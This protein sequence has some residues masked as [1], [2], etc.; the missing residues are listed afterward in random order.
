MR[1]SITLAAA[2]SI[3]IALPNGTPFP[4]RDIV[5]FLAFGV[6]VVSLVLQGTTL[7]ALIRLLGIRADATRS[8]EDNLARI[9]AVQAG[10][11]V[12]RVL[13]TGTL[14]LEE[15]A[16]LKLSIAE[17]EQRLSELTSEGEIQENARRGQRASQKYS[18]LALRAER[19][20][21]DDLWRRGIIADETHRPLQS[22][23]DHAEAKIGSQTALPI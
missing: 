9:A 11:K 14:R 10:L 17:Y 3:P 13:D 5:I 12:L 6:I 2:L 7:E 19:A 23:I 20:A 18:L 16:S 21:I 8:T 1:G 22:L 15:S 4:G